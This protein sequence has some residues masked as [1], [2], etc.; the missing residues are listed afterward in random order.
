MDVDDA[1]AGTFVSFIQTQKL[2]EE[3]YVAVKVGLKE[4]AIRA[5]HMAHIKCKVPP[6]FDSSDS[7]VLFEPAHDKAQLKT[8]GLGTGLRKIHQTNRPFVKV[9]ILN[10]M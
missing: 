8:L 4:V 2:P 6:K 9:P 10:M 5:G 1:S 7:V 3:Q